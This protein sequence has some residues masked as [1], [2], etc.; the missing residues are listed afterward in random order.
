MQANRLFVLETVSAFASPTDTPPSLLS[1]GW[2]MLSALL[3]DLAQTGRFAL[4]TLLHPRLRP[5]LSELIET[6]PN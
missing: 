3:M 2:G 1:E 5:A 6:C 4:T